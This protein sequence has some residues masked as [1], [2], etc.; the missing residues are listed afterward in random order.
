MFSQLTIAIKLYIALGVVILI[1]I[2]AFFIY[3]KGYHN[4]ELS[5]QS[6]TIEVKD[7]ED[8]IKYEIRNRPDD[9]STTIARL[10]K[11][12]Y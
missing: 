5:I 10:R 8:K 4:C 2:G 6:K 11:N 3:Q 7:A 9:V 1:A 12:S